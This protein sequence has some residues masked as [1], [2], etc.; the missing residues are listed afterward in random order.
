MQTA[1]PMKVGQIGVGNFGRYRRQSMRETG[2]F[3]LVAGVDRNPEF[4]ASAKAED[5]MV[6]VESVE[7]LLAMPELEGIVIS[8][9]IDTHADFAI[10]AMEAGKHVFVEKPL[11]GT[12]EEINRLIETRDRTGKI[13]AMGH[14]CNATDPAAR[15][16]QQFIKDGTLGTVA[17]YEEN[18]SHSGGLE[19]KPGAW[20]GLRERN[21]GGMLM[22]CGVHSLHRLNYLFGP[23][24]ELSAMFRYDANPN[25]ETADVANVLLRHESGMIGTLN[26]Y[27]VTAYVHEIRIFGTRG[28]LYI[29]THGE[30]A[31]FQ[32]RKCNEVE[33]RVPVPMP[34]L[35]KE[36]QHANVV[37]W[38]RAVRGQ[39]KADPVLEDG[40]NA[41]LPIF[42]AELSDEQ[43]RVVQIDEIREQMLAKA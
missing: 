33:E 23:I 32:P 4:L 28:N 7:K 42:A 27:H 26:C 39:G 5:G 3:T 43:R 10:K 30:G 22:Q 6:A 36:E 34:K 25:T 24:K 31:F 37:N 2:L 14:G 8:T 41:V 35:A 15:L 1:N 40:I 17:C 29:S 19:I 21:P 11:C 12:V 18:S 9:G 16:I 20:R 38:Y 13:V